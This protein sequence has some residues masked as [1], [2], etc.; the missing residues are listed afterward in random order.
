VFLGP[1]QLGQAQ[2][3]VAMNPFSNMPILFSIAVALDW[4]STSELRWQ[5]TAFAIGVV[6]LSFGLSGLSLFFFQ[7]K[8]ADRSLVFFSLFSF[9]YAIRLIFRQRFLHSLVL[10]PLEFWKYTD[11]VID[12]FIV[13]PLTLFLIEAVQGPWKTLLR[14]VLAFQIAFAMTRFYSQLFHVGQGPM[15]IIYHILIVAYCAL[16]IAYP[17]SFSR[18]Q[19]MP[20]E[21]K[22]VYAGLAIFGLFVIRNNLASLG[23]IRGRDVEAFGFLVLVCCLGYLA[24]SRTYSNE[25]R[26]LSFQKELEIARQIQSSILPQEVPRVAGLDI[27]ARYIPM[28]AVAGDFYDFLAIDENRVGIMVADVTGHGVPAALIASMLKTAL[29][30]QLAFASDP[31]QVLARL[32]HSLC[33]KFEEHFVT[34]GYLFMDVE[35]QI[36]RYAG[37]GH[38]P[39]VF[40]AT[41]GRQTT[42]REIDSNGLVLGLSEGAI[43]SS[44]ELPFRPGDRCVLYTDGVLEAKNG[45]QEEFGTSRFLKFLEAQSHLTPASL[46]SALLSE[47]TRWSEKGD[48]VSRED[49]ITLIAVGFERIPR[50]DA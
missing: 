23:V 16:L 15:E 47:L 34:A 24:A 17:F 28:A 3:S 12:N 14:W 21:V 9:L 20:R 10:A 38:P 40:G 11:L 41:D 49:D 5:L 43:Y 7:H 33:G 22:V 29:A 35:K 44:L 18:E 13:I 50:Q 31:V 26:L 8:T 1:A 37:A 6:I 25:Q 36:L 27:A 2:G 48:G 45:T 4:P 19:R 46:I 39:L 32:N 42:F 30:A